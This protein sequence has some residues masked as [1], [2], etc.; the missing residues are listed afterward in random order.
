M[1]RPAPTRR[2]EREAATAPPLPAPGPHPAFC[3]T[4]SSLSLQVLPAVYLAMGASL[5]ATPAQLGAITLARALAQAVASPLAGALGDSCDRV[6]LVAAGCG[7]WAT[8]TAGIALAGSLPL[9]LPL[10]ALNGVG[11]ALAIPCVQSIVADAVPAPARGSAF[12]VVGTAAGLGGMA[13]AWGATAAARASLF[14]GVPG[15]RVA[16]AA[17][18]ALSAGTGWRCWLLRRIRG[19]A[20]RRPSAAAVVRLPSSPCRAAAGARHGARSRPPPRPR[21]HRPRPAAWP[22]AG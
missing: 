14:G 19:R 15:W 1:G 16:F 11:L 9:M 5:A 21:P 22:V 2:T 6:R 10:A 18:A 17:V 12:G 7:L 4:P 13:A 3:L 20:E 8:C